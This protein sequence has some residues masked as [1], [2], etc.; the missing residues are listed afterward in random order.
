[1]SWRGLRATVL[2][3]TIMMVAL[4]ATITSATTA[5]PAQAGQVGFVVTP[6]Q[7]VYSSQP[8]LVM[9]GSGY[10]PGEPIKITGGPFS[11]FQV[12]ADSSGAFTTTRQSDSPSGRYGVYNIKAQGLTSNTT[13]SSDVFLTR[14]ELYNN[15]DSGN[16][17]V[18]AGSSA[19]LNFQGWGFGRGEAVVISSD[20]PG[21]FANVNKTADT[22]GYFYVSN[23][24]TN[25]AASAGVY[26]V[27][28]TGG[29]S[30]FVTSQPFNVISAQVSPGQFRAGQHPVVTVS[31]S[32]LTPGAD[33]SVYGG[34][35]GK[36]VVKADVAGEISIQEP[37]VS[38]TAGRYLIYVSDGATGGRVRVPLYLTGNWFA[39]NPRGS[40]NSQ[41]YY[42][43]GFQPNEVVRFTVS[44]P[45]YFQFSGS[46]HFDVTAN[47]VG[48]TPAYYSAINGVPA[49]QYT[50]T[51]TGL[52]SGWTSTDQLS[53]TGT[54]LGAT[55]QQVAAPAVGQQFTLSGM[56]FAPGE[57]VDVTNSNYYWDPF[58]SN[59]FSSGNALDLTLQADGSGVITATLQ[60]N[61]GAGRQTIRA[62]GRS[63]GV[64]NSVSVYLTGL[65]L[66]WGNLA[67]ANTA[68]S[69]Y[70]EGY[71]FWAGE[72]VQLSSNPAG[73]FPTA[74]VTVNSYGNFTYTAPIAA[75]AGGDYQIIATGQT[76]GYVGTALYYVGSFALSPNAVPAG[77]PSS[78]TFSGAGF[79]PN[80]PIDLWNDQHGNVFADFSVTAD[81][82]GA[83]SATRSTSGNGWNNGW[84]WVH[85]KG[86]V[87]G[88]QQDQQIHPL[89][90]SANLSRAVAGS[91]SAVTFYVR[92]FAQSGSVHL[93]SSPPGLFT[94]K[95]VTLNSSGNADVSATLLA[96]APVGTYT[97]LAQ[98]TG[99]GFSASA[100]FTIEPSAAGNPVLHVDTT[101]R[102]FNANAG[103]TQTQSV[104]VALDN[105]GGGANLNWQAITTTVSG[106]A[107]LSLNPSTGTISPNGSG[108]FSL[109]VNPTG[110]SSGIYT[111]TVTVSGQ[112]T[113]ATGL[114][115]GL[116][117]YWPAD[118][119]A[120]DAVGSHPGTTQ[121]GVSFVPG[122][123]GQAFSFDGSS[124]YVDL[125]SWFNLQTFSFSMWIKPGA[126]QI[127][128]ADIIDNNHTDYRSFVAQY[129]NSGSL[130]NWGAAGSGV[131]FTLTPGVWQ[132]LVL[133]RDSNNVNRVYL[134]GALVGT[135]AVGS[136]INYD[137]TQFLRLSRWGGGGRYFN[138]QMD[139]VRVY[140]HALSSV[141]VEG[142]CNAE[143]GAV[144][145]GLVTPINSPQSLTV[146]LGIQG[147]T[148]L[149][150]SPNHVAAGS[151][152]TVTLTATGFGPN[153]TV[154]ITGG[155][156]ASIVDKTDATGNLSR[157]VQVSTYN[158]GQYTVTIKG[159]SSGLQSTALFSLTAITA[160]P[161]GARAQ[162]STVLRVSGVGYI[163]GE[164][165]SL[166]SS[167]SGLFPAATATADAN[168]AFNFAGTIPASAPTGQYL[169]VATGASGYTAQT[170]FNL[171]ILSVTPAQT[172]QPGIQ[173]V[174]SASGYQP[175]EQVHLWMS[176]PYWPYSKLVDTTLAADGAGVFTATVTLPPDAG[177]GWYVA[178]AKGNSSGVQ[179]TASFFQTGIGFNVALVPA[180][181]PSSVVLSGSGFHQGEVINL[182]ASPSGLFSAP[183]VSTDVNGNFSVNLTINAPAGFYHVVA[184]GASSGYSGAIDLHV[185]T[186]SVTPSWQVAGGSTPL[187]IQS[188][189]YAANDTVHIGRNTGTTAP[190]ENFDRAVDA[191][192]VLTV[193]RRATNGSAQRFDVQV[194]DDRGAISTVPYYQVS[195]W[196]DSVNGT[197]GQANTFNVNGNG[198]MENETIQV[199]SN[200]PSLF[201]PVSFYANGSGNFQY[202][203]TT[204][205]SAPAGGYI[206]TVRG[207]NSGFATTLNYHVGSFSVSPVQAVAGQRPA[208]Q[209]QGNGYAPNERVHLTDGPWNDFWIPANASGVISTTQDIYTNTA[210]RYVVMA[211][212][213]SGAMGRATFY[214][215]GVSLSTGQVTTGYN[216]NLFVYGAGFGE[217]EPVSL[218]VQPA[219]LFSSTLPAK[220]DPN[221]NVGLVGSIDPTA[222]KGSYTITLTGTRT[223]YSASTGFAIGSFSASPSHVTR[224]T[225][226][227]VTLTGSGYKPGGT[228][229]FW[230]GP[231]ADNP[232]T[233]DA[234]GLF[235]Q[236]LTIDPSKAAGRYN[237][238]AYSYDDGTD[239]YTPF[240]LT[241]VTVSPSSGLASIANNLTITG[242]GY[243]S[244]DLVTVSAGPAGLFDPRTVL[245]GTDGAWSVDVNTDPSAPTSSYTI[246]AAGSDGYTAS[247]PFSIG[248]GTATPFVS[249]VPDDLSVNTTNTSPAITQ[250]IT[251]TNS[252][253]APVTWTASKAT[254]DGGSW[255][256]VSPT[257]GTLDVGASQVLTITLTP[258]KLDASTYGGTVTISPSGGTGGNPAPVAVAMVVS[259]GQTGLTVSPRQALHG[260]T[261]MLTLAGAGYAPNEQVSIS[262]GP[263]SNF[264]V[265]ADDTGAFMAT[266]QVLP[267]WDS[268]AWNIRAHGNSSS[269]DYYAPFN[270]TWLQLLTAGVTA[271]SGSP[272]TFHVRAWQ[273]YE[274]VSVS[275]TPSGLI[276]DT[277]GVADSGG[278]I[279]N[280][281]LPTN[282]GAPAGVYTVR[283][284]GQSSGM[285]MSVPF[286]MMQLSITPVTIQAGEHPVLTIAGYGFTP[287]GD[288]TISNGPFGTFVVT[289][290]GS[291]TISAQEPVYLTTASSYSV[292]ATDNASGAFTTAPLNLVG[293]SLH[294][295][296]MS[297]GGDYNYLSG[298]GFLPYEQID[299]QVTPSDGIDDF[300]LNANS[301]GNFSNTYFRSR[302]TTP[303]GVHTLTATGS[304]SGRQAQAVL[305]VEGTTGFSIT[306]SVAPAGSY[307]ILTLSA[308]GFAPGELVDFGSG[309]YDYF[310]MQADNSGAITTTVQST[311]NYA[312]RWTPYARGR[313]SG[314]DAYATYAQID[315]WSNPPGVQIGFTGGVVLNGAG[316]LPGESV[317]FQSSP[318]GL[319]API[320]P[321]A[322]SA[323]NTSP[324]VQITNAA[325]GDYTITAIGQTS[326]SSASFLF[327]VGALLISPNQYRAGESPLLTITEQGFQPGELVRL[328]DDSCSSCVFP[329]GFGTV[330]DAN[331]VYST[332][333]QPTASTA[334]IHKL[335]AYGTVSGITSY[336]TLY[337]SQVS[338]PAPGQ[339]IAGQTATPTFSLRGFR[340]RVTVTLS[341]NPAGLFDPAISATDDTGALDF[342]VTLNT[343]S[344]AGMYQVVATDVA[345]SF[346]AS[347]DVLLAAPGNPIL[348]VDPSSPAF[349]ATVGSTSLQSQSFRVCNKGGG[350]LSFTSSSST[351][352]GGSWLSADSGS[353]LN[354]GSCGYYYARINPTGL[355]VGVYTG[356]VTLSAPGADA[357][358]QSLE[359]RLSI[360]PVGG[361]TAAVSPAFGSI[362]VPQRL[363]IIGAGFNPGES[364]DVT[365]G[366]F[367]RSRTTADA[368][369][370]VSLE[371]FV[372]YSSAG[373][374]GRQ[375]VTLTGVSSE[376]SAT[377]YYGLQRFDLTPA[378]A[379]AGQAATLTAD[380]W[381]MAPSETITF[382]A[383]PGDLF[384]PFAAT[385][386]SSG[387]VH[388]TF[389]TLATAPVGTYVV[390][391]VG[392][393]SGSDLQRQ[394]S[395]SQVSVN[396]LQWSYNNGQTPQL[397]VEGS[398]YAPNEWVDLWARRVNN[399]DY[400]GGAAFTDFPVLTDAFGHFGVTVQIN[401]NI[402]SGDYDLRA[403]GR[404][405]G[406]DFHTRI[407]QTDFDFHDSGGSN[408]VALIPAGT[409]TTV[410]LRGWGFQPGE[411]VTLSGDTA[412]LNGQTIATA[413]SAGDWQLTVPIS[414]TAGTYSLT[415]SGDVSGYTSSSK[416]LGVG[417]A[418]VTPNQWLTYESPTLTIS[419]LGFQPEEQVSITGGPFGDFAVMADVTGAVNTT[420]RVTSTGNYQQWTLTL[421]G[422]QSGV[423]QRVTLYQTYVWLS[424]SSS[425]ATVA[426][427]FY[428]Y[429]YGFKSG[430]TISVSS[431]PTG[432]FDPTTITADAYGNKYAS[433]T[434][435]IDAAPGQY[436]VVFTGQSSGYQNSA[437]FQVVAPG[438][439]FMSVSPSSLTFGAVEGAGVPADQSLTI[440]N[441][442][443]GTTLS[444][445]ATVSNTIGGNWLSLSSNSGTAAWNSAS[446]V[447]VRADSAGLSAG[448]YSGQ[449]VV[450]G[451]AGTTNGYKV[452]NVRLDVAS[453]AA[454]LT[455]NKSQLTFTTYT[456][457]NPDPQ[458][459]RVSNTGGTG[460][461]WTASTMTSDGGN[462]LDL[463]TTGGSLNAGGQVDVSVVITS[464]GLAA[465]TYT[466][467]I[468]VTGDPATLNSPKTIQV[469]L[470]TN[471]RPT[472]ADMAVS[473]QTFSFNGQEGVPSNPSSSL[474]ISNTGGTALSWSS[475]VATSNNTPWLTL[476]PSSGNVAAAG[477]KQV[478]GVNVN[479]V[480][481]FAGV[482]T[483]TITLSDAN[484]LHS[485]QVVT[486]TLTMGAPPPPGL[487]VSPS[488]LTFVATQGGV[489][490]L[491]QQLQVTNSGG[492]M[493]IWNA[494][495]ST[496]DG[497]NWLTINPDHGSAVGGNKNTANVHVSIAGLTTGV[498][499]GTVTITGAAGTTDSPREIPVSLHVNPAPPIPLY[500]QVSADKMPP[501]S[502]Y[503]PGETAVI[504]ATVTQGGTPITNAAAQARLV[505]PDGTQQLVALS[506]VGASNVYTGS[507]TLGSALGTGVVYVTA[508][509]PEG[510]TATGT[511]SIIISAHTLEFAGNQTF[512]TSLR[513]S[514]NGTVN[515]NVWNEAYVKEKTALELADVTGPTPVILATLDPVTALPRSL[516]SYNLGFSAAGLALGPHT[517][518][519]TITKLPA[520]QDPD[521]VT[522]ITRTV[523]I[524][525]P[526][527]QMS[528]NP[529]APTVSVQAGGSV[530]QTITIEN[531]GQGS[532]LTGIT[533]SLV[534]RTGGT[535]YPWVS[536]SVTSISP[537]GY[538]GSSSFRVIASPPADT[539]PNGYQDTAIQIN[540]DNGGSLQ[541][542]LT[543]YVDSNQH[544]TVVFA[545]SDDTGQAV[546]DGKVTLTSTVAPYTSRTVNLTPDGHGLAFFD[547][548]SVG[549]PYS[550]NAT[551]PHHD[552][553]VG[554][555]TADSLDTKTVPVVLAVQAIQTTW[556]VVPTTIEDV[557]DINL[558]I[559]YEV[560][561]PIPQL[562]VD[563]AL[564]NYT[565]DPANPGGP[566]LLNNSSSTSG[567]MTIYNPSRITVNNVVVDASFVNGVNVTL[568]YDGQVGNKVTISSIPPLSN[569]TLRYDTSAY[570]PV[571]TLSSNIY[572]SAD[573]TYFK[574]TPTISLNE[575]NWSMSG[576]AGI[577][578]TKPMTVSNTGY[579][580]AT[581]ITV[582]N[583][584]YNWI[585]VP[586]L[587]GDLGIGAMA[588]FPIVVNPP[589]GTPA[590]T[591]SED[592]LITA[593]NSTPDNH[594]VLTVEVATDGSFTFQGAYTAGSV[595]PST[596]HIQT[597]VPVRVYSCAD[598]LPGS[599]GYSTGGGAPTL[600]FTS[601]GGVIFTY[602][603]GTTP[604]NITP[605]PP[606]TPMA[607]E[608]IKLEIPQKATL[609]RQ[610]F[611]AAL[612]TT[613]T[614]G[615][616]LGN[617]QVTI[618]VM[619]EQGSA[620]N[621]SGQRYVDLFAIT[622]P[623]ESGYG[624]GHSIGDGQ[625]ATSEWTLIPSE[626]LG[627]SNPNGTHYKV[628]ATYSYEIFTGGSEFPSTVR[629]TT[630][631]VDITIYPMPQ[632]LLDYYVP[633]DIKANQPVKL[634]VVVRNVGAGPAKNLT[635][636]SG[637]PQIKE[638]QS[639]LLITFALLGASLKGASI[640]ANSLTLSFGDVPAGGQTWGYWVL[641]T[642]L[643]GQVTAFT[644]TYTQQDY[645]G[646]T[647]SPLILAVHTNIIVQGDIVPSGGQSLEL[648]SPSQG[649]DP[650]AL[651]NLTTGISTP[652]LTEYV[653][654]SSPA[655][656]SVPT[657]TWCVA[658]NGGWVLSVVPDALPAVGLK[659][660]L[661][662]YPDGTSAELYNGSGLVWRGSDPQG[663][664]VYVVDTPRAG[665]DTCYA[666]AYDV[667]PVPTLMG[668]SPMSA[669]TATPG[670]PAITLAVTGTGFVSSSVVK[671]LNIPL[672][673]TYIDSTHLTAMLPASNITSWGTGQIT[674]VNPAP[675]GGTSNMLPFY[676]TDTGAVVTASSV[677]TST[678]PGGTASA[679][680]G[681][682]GVGTP[683]SVSVDAS[684]SGTVAVATYATNPGQDPSFAA[685]GG[686]IDVYVAPGSS[687]TSLTI[688][689]CNLNGGTQVYWYDGSN[690]VLASNQI[691]DPVSKCVTI[692]ITDTTVPSLSQLTGTPFG[693]GAMPT[694]DLVPTELVALSLATP[695]QTVPLTWTVKNQGHGDATPSWQDRVYLSTD[696]TYD[697]GDTYLT[698]VTRSVILTA[699]NSYTLTQ[700][701][702]LPKVVGSYYLLLRTDMY[703]VLDE[704][705]ETNNTW[706]TPLTIQAPD[707]TPLTFTAPSTALPGQMV[708]LSWT[709]KNAG[710]QDVLPSWQDRV[711]LSTDTTYDSGDS[712]LTSATQSAMLTAGSSYTLTQN[713]SLPKV[714]GSYYLIFR[715]DMYNVVKELDESNNT[716]V[717]PLLIQAPDLTPTAF[718]GPSTAMPGQSLPL[719]WTV[720]N[721]GNQE[722]TPSW[723][724]R[725]YL[726]TD[727]V[728]D[729]G[730][731]YVTLFTRETPLTAGNSYTVTQSALLPKVV[732][733]N[734]YLI[735][736]SD[737]YGGVSEADENNNS[738]AIPV[739]LITKP[740]LVLTS[741]GA[742][743]TAMPGQTVPLAWTVRNQGNEDAAPSWQDRVY[744]STDTVYDSGDTYL[745]SV[746]RS[747]TVAMGGSYSVTQN[748]VLPKVGAGS[749][750]LLFRTDMYNT[751]KELDEDNNTVSVPI[752]LYTKPDL[753][754]TNFST[755]STAVP[756]Q[757]VPISWTVKNQGNGDTSSSWQ[758]RVYLSTNDVYDSGDTYLASVTRSVVVPVGGSYTVNQNVVLPKVAVGSYYLIFRTDMYDGVKELDESNN[759]LVESLT[760]VTKPELVPTALS[761]PGTASPGQAISVTWTVKNQGNGDAAPSWQDRVYLSTDNVYDSGDTYLANA[762]RG[763]ALPVGSSYSVTAGVT[764]PNLSGSYYLIVRTDVFD[765]VK[766]S[767]ES[768]NSYAVPLTL[769][770]KPGP[771]LVPTDFTASSAGIGGQ[772]I[773]LTWT[774]TN[775]GTSDAAPS[776]QDRVYLST[777][778]SYD[779][780]DTYVTSVTQSVTATAGSSY[781]VTRSVTLPKVAAGNYYLVL[782]TDHFNGVKELAETN[783]SSAVPIAVTP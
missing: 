326:G 446:S 158:A 734:Y 768:N 692:T 589:V 526:R 616:T 103:S 277:V 670:D 426:T 210:G 608:I 398:G 319:F 582:S 759:S 464:T 172:A 175:S 385:A 609:E 180:N 421:T 642:D 360:Q 482:Y 572:V 522:E 592:L 21:L 625:T 357:S 244:G 468:T 718:S 28:A 656:S 287:G 233:V 694:P 499:S 76:S 161:T 500:V 268:N 416:Q 395:A 1:M 543:V 256:S 157:D 462:W 721:Q 44:P 12:D 56:G 685:T 415:A 581:G 683:G 674:V 559:T 53:V 78:V 136:P 81:S 318:A 742:P 407:F 317:T 240:N 355:T 663:K 774:I 496:I 677:G 717:V 423:V 264:T 493:L 306:P 10:A 284:T 736:L 710:N 474:T 719:T 635:I 30:G 510:L 568:A 383:T 130:F 154:D 660:V 527:P 402:W 223:G 230:N 6:V 117:D 376:L 132:H 322:D 671:W 477:G 531:K 549:I 776:W 374:A 338:G 329:E 289:A 567:Q 211:T 669:K 691:Y 359:V 412:I 537:L 602:P 202:A 74:T 193:T 503:A 689:D 247:A 420:R 97:V 84:T 713:V 255:M 226:G 69:Q 661:A 652:L 638:N 42:A 758:D 425:T 651:M 450:D 548:V 432:L 32:G 571:S 225:P 15:S 716:S 70:F 47:S 628:S 517:L 525:E 109:S 654:N 627:G 144:C 73:L 115:I 5:A 722:S 564:F 145:S 137:G 579:N 138:G 678:N 729:S 771:D 352:S 190:F 197:L 754:P 569:V 645:K 428:A 86:R 454:Q 274:A 339:L 588:P 604:P 201:A 486:A 475:S 778:N 83:F 353:G 576:T 276:S 312:Q 665:G 557:Y 66:G 555:V 184:T 215:T 690:W 129:Q 75:V 324:S 410:V 216:G 37:I 302:P 294:W 218:S 491:D 518:R 135:G 114:P 142:L 345:S 92:A 524:V 565:K 782:L 214:L 336:A 169:I 666:I 400:W 455:L 38:N 248:S 320:S 251:F 605:P 659:S 476:S 740:D 206:L 575:N 401:P 479:T 773:T 303:N 258:F 121:G 165:V 369:G 343:L 19:S 148:T 504:S 662:N 311:T 738:S 472:Q 371:R 704:A 697:S 600:S 453:P 599:G 598:P 542:P 596:G 623:T 511:V 116:L 408:H 107:W 366:I 246:V 191:S 285:Q 64:D 655:T 435:R 62:N 111:G 765:G 310:T 746:T 424:K 779:G 613:N 333:F 26:K 270:L 160:N 189:G 195:S 760:L 712:F 127:T 49:G 664:K 51:A 505:E 118:G 241:G 346:S 173:L 429:G 639:G 288:V 79:T 217:N 523:T 469:T 723:Q 307:P 207:V 213:D 196:L 291:G 560:D 553:A 286:H 513:Q 483:A 77:S 744:L 219:G 458:S 612:Q 29:T 106:G 442:S 705:D 478:V 480:G 299:V 574:I 208:V 544:T 171:S 452:V 695:G 186:L 431:S 95:D 620:T 509:T 772:T 58:Y 9:S 735:L 682:T 295:S 113:G 419:A 249:V 693:A 261:P 489:N 595:P 45:G 438:A 198:Y 257:S 445:T 763:V 632:L 556:T 679:T 325:A 35:F 755:P 347:M 31:A 466:G 570:C 224:G 507:I 463:S 85:A 330:A 101:P 104:N 313:V 593:G 220:T 334:L 159:R 752:T 675:G 125:G 293:V 530:S 502:S 298:G 55:P 597:I 409:T 715:S 181:M 281:S 361:P 699:G 520:V 657:T 750:Y 561:V 94:E 162:Q 151:Y 266:Q 780:G 50:F 720:K 554:Y 67:K 252:G 733:G 566:M 529:L 290:S 364:V 99:N 174:A 714:L 222:A 239:K 292:K 122:K 260:T 351:G 245:V 308:R 152:P 607:H 447:T 448:S 134:N 41:Y 584:S 700:N 730:D 90:L 573:Y 497:G 633:R 545:V 515:V 658:P 470:H 272:L 494:T 737:M 532:S 139:E 370:Q 304:Q 624:S 124:G 388:A 550:Y 110:L 751:V 439:P 102:L 178:N 702:T 397:F 739:T 328:Y 501:D 606:P 98:D 323:G 708:P 131:N 267:N 498:Y 48:A 212:G 228:V 27:V 43:A 392:E 495:V 185:G 770:V 22:N 40:T 703:D 170:T 484:A 18:A 634:G 762:T 427:G 514:D 297:S 8:T 399:L 187:L 546:T 611:E 441:S 481:L 265:T 176:L 356:T 621:S 390:H 512:P 192:G 372:T 743:S 278:N 377:T 413:S 177:N 653:T 204:L 327:M 23:V 676:V 7:A 728:Y 487:Q 521:A 93:S 61:G 259:Q 610:A 391:A 681:G 179:N 283:V 508:G 614:S 68:K 701:V 626:G 344:P 342:P 54:G 13:Y 585:T 646:A 373:Y 629:V 394:F 363:V 436:Q 630:E 725:V 89:S 649:V 684:G 188:S 269:V 82:N 126:S 367:D 393:S 25:A 406:M 200:D 146:T 536:L 506:Q 465:D 461:T 316:F 563:P 20:P 140:D 473:P 587:L 254:N 387:Y 340:P 422:A 781:T 332:S 696:T 650:N 183:P 17:A 619:D 309:P 271:G 552:N 263:F 534:S 280:W 386:N 120:S 492:Q 335:R 414:A 490:P 783:N 603:S 727:N 430:E 349:V 647:L 379:V 707:L 459:F 314:I 443:Q 648:V 637:Q 3:V 667:N 112:G 315:A 199:S 149:A 680:V 150:L 59:G 539:V 748:V 100:T 519:A 764:L 80:E 636:V 236:T 337:V 417:S 296:Y 580:V 253:V 229:H 541:L 538:G 133:T 516:N 488:L 72:T 777:D 33:I 726:S 141:E 273:P 52:T 91:T 168:G 119:D 766:E 57:Y 757:T 673:T 535:V 205:A 203:I 4:A 71:G 601:G 706:V 528:V 123:A 547:N 698:S 16:P 437:D 300:T 434:T 631:A 378:S 96:T 389:S 238:R 350:T 749:Y 282:L 60:S 358:P 365:S 382:T 551:A 14:F 747:L 147:A 590:G 460:M 194:W 63:S 724:D 166:S 591:Y 440:G 533:M 540:T 451:G 622:P 688:V 167:P 34:P 331:G 485:P 243:A 380:V 164:T 456:D 275:V 301:A 686:Y 404:V 156:W 578:V 341:S 153:E 644:A 732:A 279:W 641:G 305:N 250:A 672:A 163:G 235:T 368:G 562:A 242:A 471:E 384:T 586:H 155:P 775:Q 769:M 583:P 381:G 449:I 618:N 87:S 88:I 731:A 411:G 237:L 65:N 767:D 232:T 227:G 741:Y 753:V 262:S 467:T 668:I 24:N 231:W 405:S 756:G 348:N 615:T 36:A 433:L 594:L 46:D 403:K 709:V 362:N 617:F 577:G 105:Q 2:V 711:Y 234:N 128:W 745:A 643:D 687:F 418:S 640:P 375:S 143:N 321:V 108:S 354:A 558:Q 444:W 39:Y 396:P 182:A 761:A 221:G 209:M 11:D 457:T